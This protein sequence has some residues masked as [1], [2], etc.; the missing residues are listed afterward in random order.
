MQDRCRLPRSEAR[1]G[2]AED[3]ASQKMG[4]APCECPGA[5]PVG[6]RPTK[7][8]I[9]RTFVLMRRHSCRLDERLVPKE[10]EVS[11]LDGGVDELCVSGRGA[12]VAITALTGP[13][14]EPRLGCSFCR[15]PHRPLSHVGKLLRSSREHRCATAHNDHPRAQGCDIF[16]LVG[17]RKKWPRESSARCDIVSRKRSRCSGSSPAVGSSRTSNSGSHTRD[18]S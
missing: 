12:D 8:A 2:Q 1:E 4:G 7:L 3:R 5:A 18:L 9:G 13:V 14:R 15:C 10:Q 17:R 6:P 11:I 16:G